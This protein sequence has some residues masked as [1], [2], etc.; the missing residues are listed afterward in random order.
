MLGFITFFFDLFI[1]LVIVPPIEPKEIDYTLDKQNTPAC[2]NLVSD[3]SLP[4][5]L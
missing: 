2:Y 1:L 4:I 5:N 3:T